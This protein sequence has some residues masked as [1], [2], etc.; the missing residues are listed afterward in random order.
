MLGSGVNESADNYDYV[1]PG[2]WR[3]SVFDEVENLHQCPQGFCL[4]QYDV[5]GLNPLPWIVDPASDPLDP[6]PGLLPPPITC[7]E[8]NEGPLCAVCSP[9]YVMRAGVC[10]FCPPGSAFVNVSTTQLGF[11]AL[12]ASIIAL[13]ILAVRAVLSSTR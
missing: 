6:S 12:A 13:I 4:G 10:K 3:N 5:K 2:Y 7:S 9:S 1:P 8:G 11:Y